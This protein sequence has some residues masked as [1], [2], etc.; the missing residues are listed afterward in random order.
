M[1]FTYALEHADGTPA[2]PPIL[3]T[4][5]PCWKRGDAIPLGKRM[6]RVLDVRADDPDMP[7]VLVVEDMS[8]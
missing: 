1:A 6:L 5:Q 7:A 4:V 3:T 8:G 2:E